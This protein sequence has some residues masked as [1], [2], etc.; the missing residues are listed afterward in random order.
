MDR[1]SF[2]RGATVLGSGMIVGGTLAGCSSPGSRSSTANSSTTSSSASAQGPPDWSTLRA[3]LTGSV[4]RPE[5]SGYA[6]AGHLYNAI[7][8][9]SAAAIAQC[10]STSDVQRCLD[11]ARAHDVQVTA[12]SGGHSYGGYS[13]C[14]GLVIDV[15]RLNAISVAGPAGTAGQKAVDVGA[16]SVLI[17]IYSE[18]G[19]QGLLLPGGSCPTVGIAGLALG[20]GVGVFSRAYG[21]TCDQ[22]T[23]VEI[24]T[25]DG[26]LR[27]CTAEEYGDLFWACRGGGGGNFGIVTSFRFGAH[28]VPESIT[29]FTLEWPWAEAGTVLDAWCKWIPSAPD[30]LWANC[31]M[32]SSGSVG[33]GLIKVTGVFIGSVAAC[34]AALIP[35]TTAIGAATTY[36]F[37]GPE[38]YLTASMIEA[39]CEGEPVAQCA[40]P[41]QSPFVA[42]SSYIGAPLPENA[43]SALVSAL[44]SAPSSLPGAGVGVVF[45]GYG[46]AINQVGASETAFV[47]RNA[48]SCAQYSITYASA[49]PAQSA[50]SAASTW[51]QNL[52]DVFE[53]VTQGS[54]QNYIDPTL[55]D[56]QD[57]YYG[58]NLPRLRQVK[59]GYDPDDVFHFAQSIPT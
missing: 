57:A 55:A 44:S 27:R 25:A 26:T 34:S 6:A 39:G 43:V 28:P 10:A 42:K 2:L 15:S 1:R 13:S 12:H 19:A 5:D 20:G 8:A 51:L 30:E 47:H 37:V 3:S 48:I 58:A 14:P 7:Y 24:V 18:L 32:F 11:F 9:P 4:F 38:D 46:G 31:Q 56:W 45:D 23:A 40:A 49:P 52:H 29:L 50:L 16:G 21:L 35:L 33:G 54:Y 17:D 22:T 59:R 53:P 36:R 41:T